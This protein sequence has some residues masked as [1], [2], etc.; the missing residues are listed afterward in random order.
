MQLLTVLQGHGCGC[1]G[2]GVAAAS[3][4]LRQ[5][6]ETTNNEID[7]KQSPCY[8]I[9]LPERHCQA[10][11]ARLVLKAA[12]D[13]RDLEGDLYRDLRIKSKK[14]TCSLCFL[15]SESRDRTR[16]RK[17]RIS[18][19]NRLLCSLAFCSSGESGKKERKKESLLHPLYIYYTILH[20][21]Y[22]YYTILHL[23]YIYLWRHLLPYIVK[24]PSPFPAFLNV[25]H[26]RLF[27]ELF[28]WSF[29]D[30]EA[31]GKIARKCHTR[32]PLHKIK[33]HKND[34]YKFAL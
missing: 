5:N 1:G 17:A 6:E 32:P 3:I 2:C 21:L 29:L 4:T 28:S 8:R 9:A 15:L 18:V 11:P 24:P 12:Q 20:P 26:F 30:R 33:C 22:L 25:K 27:S 13:E 7:G 16:W 19:S 34:K 23:L 10:S 31:N 14:R